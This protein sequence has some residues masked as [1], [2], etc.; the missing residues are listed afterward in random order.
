MAVYATDDGGIFLTKCDSV[1]IEKNDQPKGMRAMAC[2]NHPNLAHFS[3]K[4]YQGSFNKYRASTGTLS[5]A[6]DFEFLPDSHLM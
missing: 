3:L 2:G 1:Q 4:S 6:N 5:A